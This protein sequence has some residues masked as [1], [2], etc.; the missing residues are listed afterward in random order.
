MHATGFEEQASKARSGNCCDALGLYEYPSL[1]LQQLFSN[2]LLRPHPAS[3]PSC[4][5]SRPP[6]ETHVEKPQTALSKMFHW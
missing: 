5:V 3:A 4:S 2:G 6:P 1:Q